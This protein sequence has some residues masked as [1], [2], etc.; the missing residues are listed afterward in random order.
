MNLFSKFLSWLS[1]LLNRRSGLNQIL[2]VIHFGY[3]CT[4]LRTFASLEAG[5]KIVRIFNPQNIS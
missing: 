5:A 3:L 2:E 1:E 4:T